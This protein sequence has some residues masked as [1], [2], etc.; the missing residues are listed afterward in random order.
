MSKILITGSAGFI[1][2]HLSIKLLNMGKEVVGIDNIN[3]YY[4]PKLKNSRLK[5]LKKYKSF[6]FYK[7]D[8]QDENKLKKVFIK[9]KIKYV[10][11]LA[12][13]AG[14]RY[15]LINPKSYIDTNIVGFY[16]ILNLSRIYKIKHF[17]YASTSS[18]YGALTNL[19]FKETYSTDHPIQLYAATKK[20]NEI[21][22]HS[23]SHIYNIPTTGLRFFTVYGPWGRPDM[24]LFKFTKNILLKKKIEVFNFGKH[25]RDFTYVEDIVQGII[26][27]IYNIPKSS[28]KF[29]FKKPL[30][31]Y[32]SAPFTIYNIGNGK[33][34]KLMKY[35]YEIENYLK[36]K[37]KKKFLKLQK[38]D[39]QDTHSDLTK[40]KKKLDY[41]STTSV[42]EGVKR[43]LDWYLL[44]YK[45]K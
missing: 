23:Y 6:T 12:A 9:N 41:K 24:A 42:K 10:V 27:S 43:F 40:I 31:S 32:S 14:V 7:I 33:S 38:G 25:T 1:G 11:N 8:I 2:F 35:I 3:N 36:I 29:N 16:N 28:K 21:I 22:A 37:S 4:D 15:S 5:I 13:Q 17:V 45:I 30:L 18:V 26:K 34:V 39:I 19:P 44:Y 20:S